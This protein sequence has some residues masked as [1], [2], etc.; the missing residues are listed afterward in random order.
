[1]ASFG[2]RWRMSKSLPLAFLDLGIEGGRQNQ[3]RI[4]LP[5]RCEGVAGD[6]FYDLC[7]GLRGAEQGPARAREG[8]GAA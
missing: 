4:G 2:D 5:R 6:P 8:T 3:V 1:M 7:G